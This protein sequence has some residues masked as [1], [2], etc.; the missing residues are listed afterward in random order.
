MDAPATGFTNLLMAKILSEHTNKIAPS[1][2]IL[3][4]GFDMERLYLHANINIRDMVM[5]Y[6]P[7]G[8]NIV[9]R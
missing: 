1:I 3:S 6:I 8:N 9:P 2:T 4:D 5:P 7:T